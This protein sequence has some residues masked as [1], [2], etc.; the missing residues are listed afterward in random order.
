[1]L[2]R[3]RRALGVAPNNRQSPSLT[4][5]TLGPAIKFENNAPSWDELEALVTERA[6][7]LGWEEPDHVNG[8]TNPYSLLR[9]FG[10]NDKPRVKLYRDHAAWCPYCHKVW[11]LLEEKQIP[12]EVEKINMR[13]YGPKPAS[14]MQKVPSGLLPVLEFNGKIYT[15]SSVIMQLLE[16]S[17][18]ERPMLPQ[19]NTPLHARAETLMRLERRLFSDWLQWLCYDNGYEQRKKVFEGRL[20]EVESALQELGGPYFLGEAISMVD[21]VFVPF[22]ERMAASVLYYKGLR[23]RSGRWPA[24]ARWFEAMES[25][26]TYRGTQS[27]YYTHVHDLPPQLGGCALAPEGVPFANAIDGRDDKSWAHPLDALSSASLEAYSAGDNPGL[28]TFY[29]AYRLIQNRDNVTTFALRG[30]GQPGTRPVSAAL[31]DPSAIPKEES[32][33]E[34]DSALRHVAHALLIGY[35]AKQSSPE[36]ALKKAEDGDGMDGTDVVPSLAYMRDRICVPRD[37]SYP[38]ARQLRAHLNWAID[39]LQEV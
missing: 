29:P 7:A 3:V 16:E 37:L 17:F 10:T 8:P 38:Q 20:N 19:R 31:C 32:R 9:L 26:S 34:V 11:L 22:L 36:H 27:D 14:F 35:N 18:P 15:E 25:R 21:L 23:I 13:C 6:T 4:K 28:D 12:Y 24:L 1:V 39:A 30:C 33:P 5:S 2:D